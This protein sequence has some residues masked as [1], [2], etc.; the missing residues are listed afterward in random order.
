[1]T[2]WRIGFAAGPKQAIAAMSDIQ[3]QSTSNPN[4][5]AQKAAVAA[6]KGPQDFTTMMRTEFDRRRR[7]LVAGLN[8]IPGLSCRM[9]PGAF[10]A[11]PNVSALYGKSAGDRK[12]DSS[13]DLA[14][15]L[16]EKAQV[17]LVPG[18]AFGDDKF[19]RL[20]YAT[21]E[22]TLRKGIERIGEAVAGLK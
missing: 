5:I 15:Y 9:P 6:L 1:M 4:S 22:A 19:I 11:F 21:S 3:S 16:L 18:S 8:A 12:I 7:I 10:F 14:L 13:S 17:A 20:S 2:G